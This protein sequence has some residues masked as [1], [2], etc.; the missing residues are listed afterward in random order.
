MPLAHP[1]AP[2]P[3]RRRLVALLTG[4]LV[5]SAAAQAPQ[6]TPVPLKAFATTSWGPPFLLPSTG[7][8]PALPAGLIPDWYAA[9]SFALKRPI[10]VSYFPTHRLAV[11]T[12]TGQP[13]LGC[14]GS[15]AWDTQDAPRLY[16]DA[17]TPFL[18]VDEV[19]V[20]RT[21]TVT[22]L[23]DLHGQRVG[24]VS[25]Y[26]Y[27][28]LEPA[29]RN[30]RVLREDAPNELAMLRKQLLGRSD[31][32]VVRRLTLEHLQQTDPQ[33]RVLQ[34]SPWLV[35]VTDLYC[36]VRRGGALSL[37]DLEAAQRQL[38]QDGTLARL[39]KRYGG[40]VPAP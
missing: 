20:S 13:D 9:L 32:A 23:A 10:Q 27:P 38:L 3:R 16:T 15:A 2:A 7:R 8:K 12:R 1:S 5:G 21:P 37:A 40:S 19:L 39:L 6:P 35:S 4:A 24:V 34:A 14:F 31:H 18:R 33:W 36:G 30:G 22:R 17:S 29:F 26:V 28:S 11:E 25:G